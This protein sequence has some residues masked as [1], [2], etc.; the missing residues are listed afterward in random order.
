VRPRAKFSRGQVVRV[1]RHYFQ[2]TKVVYSADRC[3][4]WDNGW[5]YYEIDGSV[6]SEHCVKRLSKGEQGRQP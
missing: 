6:Y 2:I 5:W 3:A 1:N 4:G